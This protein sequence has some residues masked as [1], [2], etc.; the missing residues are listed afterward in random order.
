M[1]TED[2]KLFIL[3]ELE[4]KG[5]VTVAEI[6]KQLNSS[7]STI[8]RDLIQMDRDGL[9]VKVHGGAM[10]LSSNIVLDEPDVSNKERFFATEKTKIGKF[11]ASLICSG[12]FVFIDA[13][14]T[15][16]R[17]LQF[18]TEKDATYVTNGYKH[19][20]IL[21]NMG[22]N[23][24]LTGGEVKNSTEAIIGT[25][26]VESLRRY[27]FTKAFVGTNG[28]SENQG[29][30]T[31]TNDEANIKK[32]VISRSFKSFILADHSKFNKITAISFSD[33]NDACIITDFVGNDNYRKLTK[34]E[35]V[36]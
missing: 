26:C 13:G 5:S 34:I 31:H 8:R 6:V 3:S 7:E 15:T 17:M 28:I 18:I 11:A 36:G 22:L 29:F 14:T 16:K 25:E 2:R 27:N 20:A 32:L 33:L 4:E 9:L 10:K 23:V 21:A 19:A 30:S 35:E 12:D 1:L 24:I